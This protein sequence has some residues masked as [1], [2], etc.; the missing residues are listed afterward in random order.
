[1]LKTRPDPRRQPGRPRQA[2]RTLPPDKNGEKSAGDP[3]Q[4]VH[5]DVVDPC[6][7]AYRIRRAPA[8]VTLPLGLHA[9]TVAPEPRLHG[10]A[11]QGV[12]ERPSETADY[13][14]AGDQLASADHQHDNS[15]G[16]RTEQRSH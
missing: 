11:E 13:R 12:E 15:D 2:F 8:I 9:A 7:A 6:H 4:E 10:G 16:E 5:E 14:R 3:A 1:R